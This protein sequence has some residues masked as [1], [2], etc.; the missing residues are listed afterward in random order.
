MPRRLMLAVL[1]LSLSFQGRMIADPGSNGTRTIPLPPPTATGADFDRYHG[2]TVADPYRWLEDVES[3]ATR[4]WISQQD[5]FFRSQIGADEFRTWRDRVDRFAVETRYGTPVRRGSALYLTTSAANGTGS[6]RLSVMPAEG[7][8]LREVLGLGQ[9][10]P[11]DALVG[12]SVSRTGRYIAYTTALGASRWMRLRVWDT[13]EGI[14]LADALEGLHSSMATVAWAPDDQTLYYGRFPRPPQDREMRAA[15][16]RQVLAAHRIGSRQDEDIV[17]HG[18]GED[19]MRWYIPRVSDDGRYLIVR[20]AVGSDLRERL[21]VKDLGASGGELAELRTG[22]DAQLMVIGSEGARLLLQTDAQ[23]PRHRVVSVDLAQPGIA[24]WR[25]VVPEPPANER[26]VYVNLVGDRLIVFRI[27]DAA[28]LVTLHALDGRFERTV[29]LPPLATVWGPGGG[30]PGFL[31]T[32]TDPEAYFVT[33]SFADAGTVYRLDVRSGA[34]R[35]VVA[36]RGDFDPAAF[37]GERVFYASKDGTRIPMFVARRRDTPLDGSRS[38]L[39]YGYGVLG[40]PAFPWYQPQVLAWLDAGGIYALPCIRG[41]GEYG[42]SW[43]QAGRRERRQTTIDDYVAAAD[44]LIAQKYANPKAVIANGGS[45]SGFVAAAAVQQRPQAF[46]AALIDIPVLDL[47]RY[48]RVTGA[49]AW[50]DDLG[51]AADPAQFA[52]LRALS[53]YHHLN[54]TE[55]PCAPPTLVTAGERDQTAAPWHAY[56]FVA[57]LQR[58]RSCDSPSWLQVAWGAGHT[59][60]ATPADARD[61]W[62]RQLA[63][64]ARVMPLT[65]FA[66]ATV[67]S[68]T[69]PSQTAPSQSTA[70]AAAVRRSGIPPVR[71]LDR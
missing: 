61:T 14:V 8:P 62:A 50:I 19:A 60:G 41:G 55:Q 47:L 66:P 26:I 12:F 44:W 54:G 40:W 10:S 7:E 33:N 58:A 38:V 1:T 2:V 43:H 67:S 29:D 20:S 52:A 23:A 56:K 28:P 32:R 9:I 53:P 22:V 48:D 71:L 68:K 42:E 30:G 15:V 6:R 63:F 18:P 59:F 64:L 49:A 21:W 36:A 46:G 37:V 39:M 17:I 13:R 11:D 69:T 65:G 31:G 57:A 70:A 51:S 3:E 34:M 35:S 24:H 16:E 25:E 5:A 45:L 4:A 27:R